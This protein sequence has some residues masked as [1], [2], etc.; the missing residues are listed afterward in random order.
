MRRPVSLLLCAA[1]VSTISLTAVA[2]GGGG[3]GSNDSDAV[4][5][6]SYSSEAA[7]NSNG[8]FA[9][10]RDHGRDR[11]LDRVS[12][13]GAKHGHALVAHAKRHHEGRWLDDVRS[14]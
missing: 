6:A 3:G 2:R 4:G 12:V 13:A 14:P 5:P 1:I 9:A 10:D 7:E 11:A 8:H